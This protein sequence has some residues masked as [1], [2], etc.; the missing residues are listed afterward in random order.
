V[1]K[2]KNHAHDLEHW[3]FADPENVAAI[4]CVHVLERTRPI[5]YV[6]HDEDD[7][8]WQLLCGSS[9]EPSEGRVVCLG[10]VVQHDKSLLGLSDLPLGW[11]A[12][13]PA[14]D[15]PWSRALNESAPED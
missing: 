13:R 12:D 4:C 6:T 9:H 5:L 10:C 15:Q 7:G 1:G 8:G 11:C 2:E 3:P 14:A